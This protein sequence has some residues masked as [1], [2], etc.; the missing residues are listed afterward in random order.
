LEQGKISMHSEVFLVQEVVQEAI[1]ELGSLCSEKG[2]GLT[3]AHS[4]EQMPSVKADRQRVKQVVINLIGNAVKFTEQGGITIS[5]QANEGFV[6]VL[7][8]DTGRGMSGESQ[9]LL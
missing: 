3:A 1:R 8:T 6:R 7:V 5:A 2:I 9:Q 4:L